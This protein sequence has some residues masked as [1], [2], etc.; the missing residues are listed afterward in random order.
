VLATRK[1][2]RVVGRKVVTEFMAAG[3]APGSKGT[4]LA[5]IVGGRTM[6]SIDSA[7][8]GAWRRITEDT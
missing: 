1:P 2:R 3:G 7:I 4:A 5:Q 6:G 8:P